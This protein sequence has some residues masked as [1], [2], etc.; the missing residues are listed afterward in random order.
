[1]KQVLGQSH[2]LT[3]SAGSVASI[4][5]LRGLDAKGIGAS[6]SAGFYFHQRFS[7]TLDIGLQ[8]TG[9]PQGMGISEQHLLDKGGYSYLSLKAAY[10]W[11][12]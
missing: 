1:M 4:S 7:V 2:P 3:I 10:T 6:V 8:L 11:K 5:T 9:V 12:R